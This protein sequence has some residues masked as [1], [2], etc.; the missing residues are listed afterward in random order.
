MT[1]D[2]N[3]APGAA[4]RTRGIFYTASTLNGYLA[5]DD[6][7]LDWLLTVP[8]DDV[9]G[10]IAD[11]TERVGALAMGSATYEWVLRE[12]DLLGHP[13]KWAEY[14]GDRPTFVFT[15]RELPAV[16]GAD[17]RFVDGEV[18]TR[19]A[20]MAA[21]AGNRHVWIMGGG[22]LAGQFADA[23]HL[24]EIIVTFAPATLESGKP[25]LPRNLD[26]HR[27]ELAGL[28]QIGRFAE[29]TYTVR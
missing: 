4:A 15:T 13:E 3:T 22:D 21:A 12:E 18:A 17:I 28:R 29:L 26:W 24:D 20:D 14:Y 19:W 27:L 16:A 6:D 7:S 11:F 25:L 8:Q 10:D 2:Q 1:N 9:A 5:T 23:G